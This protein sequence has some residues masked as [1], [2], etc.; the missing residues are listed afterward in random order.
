MWQ[1]FGEQKVR[2]DLS[3]D[4]FL[5][6]W[7]AV[8]KRAAQDFRS[9]DPVDALDALDWWICDGPDVLDL[10]GID[11]DEIEIFTGLVDYG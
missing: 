8:A 4:G 3:V 5:Q 2:S 6:M 9:K 11:L 7:A 10:I 1:K